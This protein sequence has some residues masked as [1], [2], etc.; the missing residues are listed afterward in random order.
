M[1]ALVHPGVAGTSEPSTAP[2]ALARPG[3]D[4]DGPFAAARIVDPVLTGD[5]R[6][7]E[8]RFPYGPPTHTVDLYVERMCRIN[9]RGQNTHELTSALELTIRVRRYSLILAQHEQPHVGALDLEA[10][11]TPEGWLLDQFRAGAFDRTIVKLLGE[12][13]KAAKVKLRRP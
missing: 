7:A 5:E 13:K 3:G 2:A 1:T 9:G 6:A 12:A 4:A 11:Q 8:L 10:E